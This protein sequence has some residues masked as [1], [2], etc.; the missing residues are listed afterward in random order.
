MTTDRWRSDPHPSAW[1]HSCEDDGCIDHSSSRTSARHEPRQISRRERNPGAH[2][3]V[4]GAKERTGSLLSFAIII[5]ALGSASASNSG[6][7]SNISTSPGSHWVAIADSYAIAAARSLQ[8]NLAIALRPLNSTAYPSSYDTLADES[9][10]YVLQVAYNDSVRGHPTELAFRHL[11]SVVARLRAR[12]AAQR[13]LGSTLHACQICDSS[14]T[15]VACR[16]DAIMDLLLAANAEVVDR[17]ING[18]LSSLIQLPGANGPLSPPPASSTCTCGRWVPPCSYK[19]AW[20]ALSA[21]L[22]LLTQWNSRDAEQEAHL[23]RSIVFTSYAL[24][25]VDGGRCL[26]T[27]SAWTQHLLP[28]EVS[29]STYVTRLARIATAFLT[30]LASPAPD[31]IELIGEQSPIYDFPSVAEMCGSHGSAVLSAGGLLANNPE[32]KRTLLLCAHAVARQTAPILNVAVHAEVKLLVHWLERN[33]R[34][35]PASPLGNYIGSTRQPCF[36]CSAFFNAARKERGASPEQGDMQQLIYCAPSSLRIHHRWQF[37]DVAVLNGE[38]QL[39]RVRV[40]RMYKHVRRHFRA[41]VAYTLGL[42]PLS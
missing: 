39:D 33:T 21:L 4:G 7:L 20:T 6:E 23:R 32:H 27:T 18:G 34:Y 22:S 13:G 1:A 25:R 15:G 8:V 40:E 19:D 28:V 9:A 30:V 10:G 41:E 36:A 37:P 2:P 26:E 42:P 24:T 31:E 35:G 14:S 3:R 12:E 17:R 5:R 38:G 16:E 29:L 11:H